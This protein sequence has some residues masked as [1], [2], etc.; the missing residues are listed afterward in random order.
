MNI[1]ADRLFNLMLGWT[2][3][4]FNSIWNLL[5]NDQ[6]GFIGFLQRFWLP[7]LVILV[8]AG[9]LADY[10]IWLVRWRPYFVW[11]TWLRQQTGKR[12]E[13]LTRRYMDNLDHAPLNLPEY[14]QAQEEAALYPVD[15]PVFFSFDDQQTV[16][17]FEPLHQVP[18][19]AGELPSEA[20]YVPFLPWEQ[21]QAPPPH[22]EEVEV[23]GPF[24]PSQDD[25]FAP[26]YEQ[27]A[28]FMPQEH[29]NYSQQA[30]YPAQNT[31]GQSPAPGTAPSTRR[32]RADTRRG[33]ANVLN[34]LK[35]SLQRQEIGPVD[36]LPP[37]V[38]QDD[39][40]HQPYIP[41]NYVYR[42]QT[43][44]QRV[45]GQQNGQQNEIDSP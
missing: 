25:L 20:G 22:A 43:P 3:S 19:T 33:L 31:P 10:I 21:Y 28:N 26:L 14:Q 38:D 18:K 35:D 34:N 37:P 27:Q 30:N 15:E 24:N 41:Q 40:F 23:P 2:R 12:R 7:I 29:N 39:V 6:Q 32:R 36:S 1:L 17:D 45:E 8:V 9:T 16:L 42:P 44:T 5:T 11:R 13:R 4:L